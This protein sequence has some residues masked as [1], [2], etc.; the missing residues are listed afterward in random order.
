MRI[1]RGLRLLCA[2]LILLT[3]MVCLAA[4]GK[5]DNGTDSV[6]PTGSAGPV[7][8]TS[9]T[10]TEGPVTKYKMTW[11]VPFFNAPT[12]A[13]K[14]EINRLL[15]EK[16]LDITI[17][18]ENADVAT[19]DE[20][21]RWLMRL[22]NREDAPDIVTTGNWYTQSGAYRLAETYFLQL[23]EYLASEAG[24]PLADAF[25]DA[26]WA[27]VRVDGK[28]YV[29]PRMYD[30]ASGDN[31]VYL[32][33]NEI[34]ASGLTA[35]DVT[36]ESV[37]SYL[38]E[39]I[40]DGVVTIPY[41]RWPLITA[42]A[43]YSNYDGIPYDTK[44]GKLVFWPNSTELLNVWN[45]VLADVRAGKIIDLSTDAKRAE[46]E[47][48]KIVAEVY[49]G[50][51]E[52]KQGYTDFCLM[53]DAG[54]PILNG[55]YGI[56]KTTKQADLA[57]RVLGECMSD[58]QIVALLNPRFGSA[59]A[60]KAYREAMAKKSADKNGA[61]TGFLPNL[62]IAQW[63][64]YRELKNAMYAVEEACYA[65]DTAGIH[66][67]ETT[68]IESLI[69]PFKDDKYVQVLREVEAQILQRLEIP[70]EKGEE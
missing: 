53:A 59:D 35:S 13:A 44:T 52:K 70:E 16:G 34:L 67:A 2:A 49:Y 54:D 10:P 46:E 50:L 68:D 19:D 5:D 69:A 63:S 18:F 36:Y 42:L 62:T 25:C 47:A 26:E 24:K 17:I 23:D 12:D 60:V 15:R 51:R 61:F 39:K 29:L 40:P 22:Q 3:A 28:T 65:G 7:G 66:H 33:V 14:D 32:R 27:R 4:C 21:D 64:A 1:V 6:T 45:S 8:P 31:G 55:T 30:T 56:F 9:P 48:N 11:A 58:P 57:I 37:R 20:Y 41:L 43:G 38:T